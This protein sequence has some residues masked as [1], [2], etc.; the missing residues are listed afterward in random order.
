MTLIPVNV[1]KDVYFRKNIEERAAMMK[2]F[3][4]TELRIYQKN[5]YFGYHK[6]KA[7]WPVTNFTDYPSMPEFKEDS[8]MQTLRSLY[9]TLEKYKNNLPLSNN[10]KFARKQIVDTSLSLSK[11]ATQMGNRDMKEDTYLSLVED[12][13]S[14][15]RK[16]YD[17]IYLL[18]DGFPN[19]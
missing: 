15:L 6:K 17:L 4:D 13:H 14:S 1:D 3:S 9:F 18:Q 19:I 10:N 12:K 5:W 7:V 8:I 11:L 16:S 2:S